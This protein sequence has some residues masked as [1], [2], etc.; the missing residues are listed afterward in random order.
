MQIPV[1]QAR[2][3]IYDLFLTAWKSDPETQAIPV[4]FD[5][6]KDEQPT[7]TGWCRINIRHIDGDQSALTN[8]ESVTR[9]TRNGIVTVQIFAETGHGLAQGD[10][11]VAVAEAAFRGKRTPSNVWFKRVSV[12]EVGPSENWFQTNVTAIFTYDE[13]V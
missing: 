10:K 9:Y 3:E 12:R 8:C 2:E 13:H 5:A 4:F 6:V 11:W 1:G 7:D